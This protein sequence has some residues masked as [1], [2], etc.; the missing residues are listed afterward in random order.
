MLPT[1]VV[2]LF[3]C[4]CLALSSA[5]AQTAPPTLGTW[6]SARTANGT[7]TLNFKGMATLWDKT[8][9]ITLNFF[10]NSQSGKTAHGALGFELQV[11]DVDQLSAFHFDDFEG[12]DAPTIGRALLTVKVQRANQ[13]TLSFTASPSGFYADANV[14]VFGVSAVTQQP[15]STAKSIFM[16]LANDKAD[17]LHI[18][19]VDPRN[20]KRTLDLSIPVAD[21]SGA[22]KTLLAL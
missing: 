20:S 3:F 2:A 18:T 16:A 1:K 8:V 9:P 22:F 4:G 7:R 11:D 15:K 17:S 14:F 12:P 19:V 10:C 5:V 6:S 13:G 21:Q